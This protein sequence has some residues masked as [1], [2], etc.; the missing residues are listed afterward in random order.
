MNENKIDITVVM[1]A[2]NEEK[3]ILASIT[4]TLRAFED[5]EINGEIIV[6]SDGSTD[7]T[8][9][10][11]NKIIKKDN[12]VR[13]IPHEVPKGIGASYWEGVDNA[14][15][16]VVTWI[17]GDNENDPWE[18][19]R[20]YKLLEHVDIV[21]PFVF[22]KEVRSLFR[23]AL[24]F[25]YRFIINT[26]FRVNFNYTN[27]TV[28]FRRSILKEMDHRSYGFFFQTDVLIRAAKRGYL[29]A[30]VPYK[31]GLR[32]DGISK[33]VTFPSLLR[34]TNGYFRLIRDYYFTRSERDKGNFSED[35]V[36]LKRRLQL[37]KDNRIASVMSYMVSLIILYDS[38]KRFLL[39][40]RTPDAQLLPDY[41]AF[42]G[43]G[44][45]EGETPDDAVRRETFEELNY[46][47]KSPE[48]VMEKN[49]REGVV[50]GRLY[51]YIESFIGDKT[52]LKLQEGQGWGWYSETEINDLKMIERDRQIIKAV[53]RYLSH[54]FK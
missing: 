32:S 41:W 43:G 47:L 46:K 10:L 48:F 12:R 51:I 23:N 22:N 5:Y 4:N 42:F 8:Q 14:N 11:V 36:T 34:V 2:L 17:P 1:P 19:F 28:L 26:T 53:S 49:F 15:G 7:K 50:E 16:N 45:K 37:N 18:I 40:H 6:I 31:L 35:S 52:T 29:F 27:G 3:N 9:D 33:A 30:E 38:E 54:M 21:I 39:Q 44:L 25:I 24:S 13:L 20:Y